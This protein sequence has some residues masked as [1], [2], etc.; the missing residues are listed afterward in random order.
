MK[1]TWKLSL[2]ALAAIVLIGVSGCGDFWNAL[3]FSIE[4]EVIDA[5]QQTKT[6][7][8]GATVVL[9]DMDGNKIAEATTDSSG[10]YLMDGVEPGTYELTGSKSG[11][12]FISRVVKVNGVLQTFPDLFAVQETNDVSIILT[13]NGD[14]VVD[15]DGKI[16][17]PPNT[18]GN[19]SNT[20]VAYGDVGTAGFAPEDGRGSGRTLVGFDETTTPNT[21]DDEER[22]VTHDVDAYAGNAGDFPRIETVTLPVESLT[23]TSGTTLGNVGDGAGLVEVG[24]QWEGILEYSVR[25]YSNEVIASTGTPKSAEANVYV[26]QGTDM[27][28]SYPFPIYT[29]LDHVSVLRIHALSYA[30]DTEGVYVIYPDL[31]ILVDGWRSAGNEFEPIV[32][33]RK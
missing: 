28:G 3:V 17:V 14:N 16:S 26:L 13:W 19:G 24:D 31:Q 6:S 9:N 32:T 22:G 7:I 25:A 18:L 5:K 29:G 1:H 33:K 8:G 23:G 20:F 27:L 15:L 11:Y 12:A 4:G 21:R 2:V 30:G 10:Y